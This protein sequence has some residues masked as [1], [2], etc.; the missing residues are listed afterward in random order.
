MVGRRR[1]VARSGMVRA[2]GASAAFSIACGLVPEAIAAD[3]PP[4]QVL[5]GP[6]SAVVTA[7]L[8]ADDDSEVVRLLGPGPTFDLEVWQFEA[9]AWLRR[10]ALEITPSLLGGHDRSSRLDT[11]ALLRWQRNGRDGVLLFTAALADSALAEG[12]C[13]AAWAVRLQDGRIELEPLPI[14][15]ESADA[16]MALDLDGDGTDELAAQRLTAVD[17]ASAFRLDV[18]RLVGDRFE[19]SFELDEERGATRATPAYGTARD[20]L[21]LSPIVD[22]RLRRIVAAEGGSLTLDE[23][24]LELPSPGAAWILGASQ[25]SVVLVGSAGLLSVDWPAGSAPSVAG[26]V[27]AGH[28][29]GAG[30]IARG[31]DG[32]IVV[33]DRTSYEP[34]S[35]TRVYDLS[36]RPLG[37]VAVRPEVAELA[38]LLVDPAAP[39][40]RVDVRRLPFRGP[41]AAGVRHG[42][43]AFVSG[44]MMIEPGGPEGFTASEVGPM[45]G[46]QPM[47]LAGPDDAWLALSSSLI[48]PQAAAYLD[49]RGFTPGRSGS[50]ALVPLDQLGEPNLDAWGASIEPLGA[51]ELGRAQADLT[52]AAPADGFEARVEGPPGTVVVFESDRRASVREIRDRP[53][54]LDIRPPASTAEGQSVGFERRILI[55]T[56]DGAASATRWAGTFIG[57]PPELVAE[58]RTEWLRLQATVSGRASAWAEVTVDGHPARADRSGGFSAAVDAAPWPRNVVVTARDPLGNETTT[59]LEVVGVAD[60]RGVPLLPLALVVTIL[61][62]AWLVLRAPRARQ[63]SSADSGAS[64]ED[65][66]GDQ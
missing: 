55:V 40:V 21:L 34:P 10:D 61:L 30:V 62:G 5:P 1:R 29:S 49:G 52:L 32:A 3:R 17:R 39:V 63:E 57:G 42:N 15:L 33:P 11:A 53:L 7:D 19:V 59:T 48:P 8:D 27:E 23:G 28:I 20:E 47:G 37:E 38:N 13:L 43:D 50:V 4:P 26:E 64:L 31:A 6:T 36:L 2:L 12:C 58:A 54:R 56:P 25:E 24:R 45:I 41:F 22:G 35:S 14:E 66:D 65:I 60:Y 44:G 51:V 16:V 46:V 18:A 9:T